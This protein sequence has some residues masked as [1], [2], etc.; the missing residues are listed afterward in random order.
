MDYGRH[1]DDMWGGFVVWARS[2]DKQITALAYL[3]RILEYKEHFLSKYKSLKVVYCRKDAIERNIQHCYCYA[4][5]HS[6]VRLFK[7]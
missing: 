2:K 3:T 1:D 7:F 6:N 5:L 4:H